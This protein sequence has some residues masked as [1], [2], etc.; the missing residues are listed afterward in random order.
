M[1]WR[2][3]DAS[4][5]DAGDTRGML[6]A[7]FRNARGTVGGTVGAP[8]CR[9]TVVVAKQRVGQARCLRTSSWTKRTSS[10]CS[11]RT[12]RQLSNLSRR[13]SAGELQASGSPVSYSVE[14]CDSHCMDRSLINGC[15]HPALDGVFS[16]PEIAAHLCNRLTR[17]A[18][19]LNRLILE[20]CRELPSSTLVHSGEL[21]RG[22]YPPFSGVRRTGVT[23]LSRHIAPKLRMPY[24]PNV[25]AIYHQ[26]GRD[27]PSNNIELSAVQRAG[28]QAG[29]HAVDQERHSSA[30]EM[31]NATAHL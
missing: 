26:T 23:Q 28:S 7:G 6:P 14:R 15:C 24:L 25:P 31:A 2:V 8:V 13:F 30:Q 29:P 19:Q 1:L 20:L 12:S 16:Q 21:H 5:H 9:A 22:K 27:E 18:D 3:P 10:L 11:G 4:A 17:T